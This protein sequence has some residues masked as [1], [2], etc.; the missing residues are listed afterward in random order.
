MVLPSEQ[1]YTVLKWHWS[2]LYL[3]DYRKGLSKFVLE[4]PKQ[5]QQLGIKLSFKVIWYRDTLNSTEERKHKY[6]QED[7]VTYTANDEM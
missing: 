3:S 7:Y 4:P 6:T 2:L 5:K 1:R